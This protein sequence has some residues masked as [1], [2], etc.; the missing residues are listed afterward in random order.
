MRDF[1]SDHDALGHLWATQPGLGRFAAVN[2]HVIGLRFIVTSLAFFAVGGAL[3]MML[4]VQLA[5]PDSAFLTASGYARTFTIHGT[6][7]MFLFAIPLLEG[8]AMVLLPKMLGARDLAFPRLSAFGYWCYVFG[9]LTILTGMGLG[10]VPEAGWFLYPPLSSAAFSPGLGTDLWLLGITFVEISAIAVAVDLIVSVLVLRAAGM[11]LMDMPVMGWTMLVVGAMMLL[12]FPPL[13]VASALLEAERTFGLPFFD[14]SRGGDPLLW[15]HLFWSFGHP[16]VYVMFLPAAAVVSSIVPTFAGRPIAG[17]RWIVGAILSVGGL[18][19]LLWGHHMF[20]A[21][22]HHGSVALFS[23]ASMLIAVPTGVQLFAWIATLAR[24]RAPTPARGQR[25]PLAM[26]WILGFFFLFVAGGLT[27]VMLAVVPFDLQALDTHFVVAHMHYVLLGGFVFPMIAALY[28]SLPLVSGR[29]QEGRL[30]RIAF[31]LCLVGVNLTFAV[32]HLTGL[33]GMPRRVAGYGSESGWTAVNLLSSAGSI[34][35][36]AGFAAVMIDLLLTLRRGRRSPPDPWRGGTLEWATPVLPPTPQV[37]D[38]I[39]RITGRADSLQPR[40]IAEATARGEGYLSRPRHGWMETLGVDPRTG[41]PR[42]IVLLPAR[43][44]RPFWAALTIGAAQISVLAGSYP[45]AGAL[46]CLAVAI[47]LSWPP[48]P[49]G[50][51]DHGPLAAGQGLF[52]PAQ[53]EHPRPPL[54]WGLRAAL[55]ADGAA[56]ASLFFA[57][58]Y[59]AAFAP[60]WADAPLPDI[61]L[62]LQLVTAGSLIGAMVT[63]DKAHRRGR[64]AM[65]DILG[66]FTWALAVFLTPIAMIQTL[67]GVTTHAAPALHLAM[68]LWLCLHGAL[69]S[70]LGGL[71]IARRLQGRISDLRRTDLIL[72]RCHNRWLAVTGAVALAFPHLV[73]AIAAP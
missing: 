18:S 3:A 51:C 24:R 10:L 12:G 72:L 31:W 44:F 55:L 70:I 58:V 38:A 34:V 9:G 45:L 22:L 49:V 53:T 61:P 71:A 4:R 52:L 35:L 7:M 11:R 46:A 15:Q 20:T 41:A 36:A 17:Y 40:R 60:G 39:P 21:G 26:L 6:V 54:L 47:L 59:L 66:A 63:A 57:G 13:M 32:M 19:F 50:N 2:H 29:R 65:I 8:L 42:Q 48:H 1:D 68:L 25:L 5:T 37:F 33:L 27:G 30:G 56:L 28:H 67:T 16:E 64:K 69:G 73:A 23:A 43:S 14:P 62:G